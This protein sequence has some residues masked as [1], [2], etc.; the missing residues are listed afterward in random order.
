M[1]KAGLP[2]RKD[3]VFPGDHSMDAGLRAAESFL[4]LD[5]RP[6]ALFCA[7]DESMIGFL[8]RSRA[9]GIECPRDISVVG[10]DDI[11][12]AEN[13]WP[14]LTTMR[15]PRND[16]G[17]IATATL[18]DILEGAT[19]PNL[20]LRIVLPSQLIVRGSTAVAPA[21]QRSVVS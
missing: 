1:R 4:A 9:S 8:S 18:L 13:Y 21:H 17:R 20:G 2:V 12:I 3:W 19:R 7:N 14:P 16:L 5:D 11:N 15:Q 10:F 6:T